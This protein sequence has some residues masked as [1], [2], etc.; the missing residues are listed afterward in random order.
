MRKFAE[1]GLEKD[2]E[3]NHDL[4]LTLK[5]LPSIAFGKEE[6]I[7]HSYDKIVEEFQ[8]VCNRTMKKSKKSKSCQALLVFWI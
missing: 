6:E 8:V 7:R 5:M 3:A 2:F 1:L 4:I